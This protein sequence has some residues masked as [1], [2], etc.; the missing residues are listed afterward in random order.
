VLPT[1][2]AGFALLIG[3]VAGWFGH[4]A[5]ISYQISTAADDIAAEMDQHI[6]NM[7]DIP[8]VPE[9]GEMPSEEPPAAPTEEHPTDGVH[10]FSDAQLGDPVPT[11]EDEST[12]EVHAEQDGA[13]YVPVTVTVENISGAETIPGYEAAYAYDTEGV[14]YTAMAATGEAGYGLS[15][16]LSVEVIYHFQVPEGTELEWVTLQDSDAEMEGGTEVAALRLS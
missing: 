3:I 13:E 1:V 11:F 5:W 6:E 12:G 7:P 14:Q 4:Q 2:A 10:E 8:A 15:P 9:E 16:G